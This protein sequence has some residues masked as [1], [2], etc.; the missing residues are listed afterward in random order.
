M[1]TCT[2]CGQLARGDNTLG[3]R[4]VCDEC[5][6]DYLADNQADTSTYQG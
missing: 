1:T 2:E 5:L 4:P 6:A 3:D